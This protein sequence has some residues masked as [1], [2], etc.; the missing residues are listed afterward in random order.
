MYFISINLV[1]KWTYYEIY[2]FMIMFHCVSVFLFV[3]VVDVVDVDFVSY[4]VYRNV[5]SSVFVL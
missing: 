3:D 4:L 5:I 1:N 2:E